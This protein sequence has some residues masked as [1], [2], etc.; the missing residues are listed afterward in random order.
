M[1]EDFDLPDDLKDNVEVIYLNDNEYVEE[2]DMIDNNDEDDGNIDGEEVIQT[3]VIDLA[4]VTFRKHEKSIFSCDLS[5]DGLF[6]VTGGEDDMA[7]VWWTE[8]CEVYMECT[9]HKDSVTEVSFSHDCQFIVTGDMSGLIQVWSLKEKK[10]I[11]CYECDDLEWL[12]W[13][14]MANILVAGSQIG[15][16]Y[17]WQ[18]PQG[19]CKVLPSSG[20]SAVSGKIMPDGKKLIT[21]YANGLVK[22]WDM[23]SANILWQANVTEDASITSIDVT[24]D[25]SLIALA[26]SATIL[27]T[28][29]GKPISQLLVDGATDVEAIAFNTELNVLITGSLKGQLCIWDIGRRTLR[30]QAKIECAVTV[31]R[32]AQGNKLIVGAT[33]GAIYVCDIRTG[34]LIETLTGHLTEILSISVSKDGKSLLT[35]SDDGTAKLF[36]LK[37]D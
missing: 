15:D 3:E 30:H 18:I 31:I 32:L 4:K 2:D 11:W 25:G 10:L 7:Y 28:I 9:G 20:I 17:I 1:D 24:N 37:S 27:K 22:L 6:A 36:T 26:P 21:G 5:N 34:T 8:N 23:K 13:H 14:H 29:D 35:T 33:D 12:M 19:N 16:I